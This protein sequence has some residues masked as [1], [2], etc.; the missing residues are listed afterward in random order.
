M[1]KNGLFIYKTKLRLN[2]SARDV[3][4]KKYIKHKHISE[5]MPKPSEENRQLHFPVFLSHVLAEGR[6]ISKHQFP[7][8]GTING[9]EQQ[10]VLWNYFIQSVTCYNTSIT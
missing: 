3:S 9:N 7:I 10:T 5:N 2:F 4:Y 6:P 8:S 1:L